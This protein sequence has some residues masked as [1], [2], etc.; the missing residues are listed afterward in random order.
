MLSAYKRYQ[1][2]LRAALARYFPHTTAYLRAEREATQTIKPAAV[3]PRGRRTS[4]PQQGAAQAAS[5][6]G[7]P[8]PA[9]KRPSRA[10]YG[11][12]LLAVTTSQSQAMRDQVGAAVQAGL[13]S[14]P[15]DEQWAMI[16]TRQP[17]SRIFAGAGSGKSSTLV[18][19]MVF[20]LC[21]LG[22]EP[23]QLTVIS[24]TNAS[25]AQ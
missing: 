15:S 1:L 11:P 2:R 19:R 25:C 6:A 18:L 13:I 17:L 23:Q 21:H 8:K 14:A 5:K 10:I 9:G 12:A 22:V 24:F 7:K 20:M 3:T 16:L 4:K